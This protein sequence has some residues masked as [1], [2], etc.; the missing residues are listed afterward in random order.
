MAQL[1]KPPLHLP[2][3]DPRLVIHGIY[4]FI[5]IYLFHNLIRV[6]ANELDQLLDHLRRTLVAN[7]FLD[8]DG[9]GTI[10]PYDQSVHERLAG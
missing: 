4:L 8:E 2:K 1:P 9:F 10:L 5:C 7:P 3:H 6:C